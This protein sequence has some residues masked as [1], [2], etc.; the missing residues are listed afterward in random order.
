[1]IIMADDALATAC[2]DDCR[3]RK[4]TRG[5]FSPRGEILAFTVSGIKSQGPEQVWCYNLHS[6]QL[7]SVTDELNKLGGIVTIENYACGTGGVV[8]VAV[9]QVPTILLGV[10][11]RQRPRHFF[12]AVTPATVEE[13]ERPPAEIATIFKRH[14]HS[15]TARIG[16]YF[17]TT[18]QRHHGD[19]LFL[20]GH[21]ERRSWQIT[22]GGWELPSFISDPDRLQVLYPD[23]DGHSIVNYDL[24]TRQSRRLVL[25]NGSELELLDETRDRSLIA[26]AVYGPCRYGDKDTPA[27][28]WRQRNVCFV[29]PL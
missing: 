7:L 13:I 27:R 6:Q 23:I 18:E 14:A 28:A 24:R 19:P 11:P 25:P 21:L 22:V 29:K 17:V 20:R 8:Y 3:Y 1:M 15:G 26:Y 12:V 16:P 4:F 9:Q 10:P 2:P 5:R